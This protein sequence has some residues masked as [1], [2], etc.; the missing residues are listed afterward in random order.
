MPDPYARIFSAPGGVCALTGAVRTA[1]PSPPRA[2][3]GAWPRRA[4]CN[5]R[6]PAVALRLRSEL[7]VRIGP[8]HCALA[9][10]C[11]GWQARPAVALSMAGDWPE[12]ALRSALQALRDTGHAL[13][14]SA[15]VVLEDECLSYYLL[16]AQRRWR[17]AVDRARD[18][19]ASGAGDAALQVTLCLAPGGRRWLAAAVSGELV[20]ALSVALAAQGVSLR[21]LRAALGEDLR[22]RRAELPRGD[23]LLALLRQRGLQLMALRGGALEALSWEPCQVDEPYTVRERLLAF[24]ERHNLEN[25]ETCVLPADAWQHVRLTGLADA[26]GWR[27]LEPLPLPAFRAPGLATRSQ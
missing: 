18:L 17:D 9:L 12:A 3:A 21:S 8:Q 19:F 5:S 27:L 14:R 20:H 2:L 7:W 6:W 11:A 23:G 13:P 24:A 1:R 26:E 22:F 15:V 25:A 4:P 16:P 10:W